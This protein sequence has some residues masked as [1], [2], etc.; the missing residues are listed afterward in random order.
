MSEILSDGDLPAAEADQEGSVEALDGGVASS[1]VPSVETT[2]QRMPRLLVGQ[3]VRLSCPESP[4][5]HKRVGLIQLQFHKR[6]Y[7]KVA[8]R[9]RDGKEADVTP[10]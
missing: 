6:D 10:E 2:M 4:V 8:V 9:F 3:R 1:S 5:H 7:D